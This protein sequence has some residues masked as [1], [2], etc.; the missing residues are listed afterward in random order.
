MASRPSRILT[1]ALASF[2]PTTVTRTRS[3]PSSAHAMICAIDPSMSEVSVV[4][5]VWR[6]IGCSEPNLTGPAV[7]VRVGRRVTL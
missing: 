3:K 5:I 1:Q 6:T 7:T 4:A 2:M